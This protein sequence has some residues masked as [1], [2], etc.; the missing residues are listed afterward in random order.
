MVV[1]SHVEARTWFALNALDLEASAFI[2]DVAAALGATHLA[3]QGVFF[4]LGVLRLGDDEIELLAAGFVG[5]QRSVGRFD[6]DRVFNSDHANQWADGVHQRI[7]TVRGKHVPHLCVA[8]IV[9]LVARYKRRPKRL[10]R[11]NQH[12]ATWVSPEIPDPEIKG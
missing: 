7:A 12:P 8:L 6:D 11:S 4:A 2:D 3:E 9:F 5:Q 10:G 1:F